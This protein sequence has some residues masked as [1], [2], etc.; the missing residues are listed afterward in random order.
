V[1]FTILADRDR[2]GPAGLFGG[3]AGQ[4]AHYVLNPDTNPEI[5]SSKTTI[6]LAAGDIV[7]IQTT[8]GGGYGSPFV[9]DEAAV[10]RDVVERR[11]SPERAAEHYGVVLDDA[12]TAINEPA[13]TA[14]RAGAAGRG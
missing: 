13:T 12:A 9:R 7:S 10:L 8:G 3:E 6:S 2:W 5:L 1:S 14:R 11:V 4:R